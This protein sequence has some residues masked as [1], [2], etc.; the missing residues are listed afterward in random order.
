MPSRIDW[1]L[2]E[3]ERSLPDFPSERREILL[4]EVE[5]HLREQVD[6]L[7]ATGM[8]ASEADAEAVRVFG[9][10]TQFAARL[11][12]E[13]A[14]AQGRSP[15]TCL[16]GTGLA[17]AGPV[18]G[19]LALVIAILTPPWEKNNELWVFAGCV[20]FVLA[21]GIK[22]RRLTL[23]SIAT[24]YLAV[25]ALQMLVIIGVHF[26]MTSFTEPFLLW[27]Y[28]TASIAIGC[29]PGPALLLAIWITRRTRFKRGPLRPA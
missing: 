27:R 20:A 28:N 12:D 3:L 25:C 29:L 26:L 13:V 7:V 23:A 1:Y 11:R 24:S 8:T 22:S 4:T 9:N 6:E 21:L 19:P 14:P 17:I 5:S 15:E 18:V 2:T 16:R 10:P